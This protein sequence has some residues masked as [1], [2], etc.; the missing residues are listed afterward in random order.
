MMT[1]AVLRKS[2]LQRN[3]FTFG[4]N[5]NQLLKQEMHDKDVQLLKLGGTKKHIKEKSVNRLNM[6]GNQMD[7]TSKTTVKLAET[8]LGAKT[9]D[10]E[11]SIKELNNKQPNAQHYTLI[12]TD[13]S[14]AFL[15]PQMIELKQ[16]TMDASEMIN[17]NNL[18]QHGKSVAKLLQA[19]NSKILSKGQLQSSTSNPNINQELAMKQKGVKETV[20]LYKLNMTA[21]SHHSS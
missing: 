21:D 13:S 20:S 7:T 12:L 19:S 5:R 3:D 18:K 11:Q 15:V 2:D 6:T 16:Q 17:L 8:D 10:F 9:A 14:E 1:H 4:K